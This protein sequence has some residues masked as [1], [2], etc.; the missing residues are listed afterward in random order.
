MAA[1]WAQYRAQEEL[2]IVAR[3]YKVR[4]TLFHGRGGAAGRGGT[5]ARMAI[6]SQP[7]G[8]VNHNMRVT[9]QGEMI[10]FK[11]GSAPL[12]LANLDLVL[13]ATIEASLLPPPEPRDNWRLLMD[14]LAEVAN[15]SYREMVQ[16]NPDF[17]EYFSEGLFSPMRS[18]VI[19]KRYNT[20]LLSPRARTIELPEFGKKGRK[21]FLDTCHLPW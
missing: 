21:I 5:P 18:E 6:L 4:L 17:V 7:P 9:E 19:G 2:V 10:R 15:K 8:S 13:S 14:R 12:A 1:A 3:K 16:D 11:Y 20:R